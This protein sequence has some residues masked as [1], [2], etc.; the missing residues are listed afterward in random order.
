MR[1]R[2]GRCRHEEIQLQ[3]CGVMPEGATLVEDD[4]ARARQVREEHVASRAVRHWDGHVAVVRLEQHAR[5]ALLVQLTA[6]WEALVPWEGRML[7]Q[8]VDPLAGVGFE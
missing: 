1:R 3:D 2:A 5:Q 8:S 7:T 4:P 6:R